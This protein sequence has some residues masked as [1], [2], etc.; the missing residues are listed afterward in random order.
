MKKLIGLILLFLFLIPF[1]INSQKLDPAVV[2]VVADE[3][4]EFSDGLCAVKKGQK[5]GFIDTTG[6]LVINHTLDFYSVNFSYPFFSDGICMLEF[7]ENGRR[8]IRYIDKT[9]KMLFEFK[10]VIYGTPFS[11]G[12]A[13][14]CLVGRPN[15]KIIYI[16]KKG[17][18]VKGLTIIDKSIFAKNEYQPFKNGYAAY[19]DPNLQKYGFIDEKGVVVIKPDFNEVSYFSDGL[20][21]VKNTTSTGE[22][23]WG[24]IDEKGKLVID[25]NF[26]IK[27]GEFS[28]G[29]AAVVSKD[30]KVGYINKLGNVIIEPQYAANYGSPWGDSKP[31]PFRDSVAFACIV[32]ANKDVI[33]LIDT[34]GK[35]VKQ[36]NIKGFCIISECEEDS[37]FV[38]EQGFGYTSGII[39]YKG[40][41][42]VSDENF[43]NISKFSNNRAWAFGYVNDKKYEGFI[44]KNGVFKILKGESQ[45]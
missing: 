15:N 40:K 23:K 39:S 10:E 22:E 5:W 38:Y 33:S 30:N 25:F 41:I 28:D 3:F 42:L 6:N 4:G 32:N 1:N 11:G 45:F 29:L 2:T 16:N 43:K 44:D 7:A 27:P 14:L 37:F 9:G 36:M 18:E 20:A 8:V 19:Y 24:F 31:I 26:S 17:L 34:V 13:K 21:A 35:V 12:F